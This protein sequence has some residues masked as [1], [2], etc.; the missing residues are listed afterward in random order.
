[1]NSYTNKNYTQNQRV[2][3]QNYGQDPT[4]NQYQTPINNFNQNSN[5]NPIQSEYNQVNII[6]PQ[7]NPNYQQNNSR[8][9]LLNQM[10]I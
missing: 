4:I 3:Y 2:Q 9:S 6:P 7:I 10:L 8:E 5:M 1:M